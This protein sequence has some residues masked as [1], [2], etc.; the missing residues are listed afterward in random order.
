MLLE[1]QKDEGKNSHAYRD[2]R[3]EQAIALDNI[4]EAGRRVVSAVIFHL[5]VSWGS[6][7]P[8]AR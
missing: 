1:P 4:G 7:K 5:R 3:A 2:A 6:T 8:H